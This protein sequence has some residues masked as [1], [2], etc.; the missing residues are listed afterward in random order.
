M[1]CPNMPIRNIISPAIAVAIS[2]LA[3]ALPGAAPAVAVEQC[4]FI[5]AKSERE[6]CYQRQEAALADKRKPEVAPQSKTMESLQQLKH[7]DEAL[8]RQLHSICRGC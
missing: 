1:G 4:R 7:E 5:Q 6:A 8:N 2:V 3:C